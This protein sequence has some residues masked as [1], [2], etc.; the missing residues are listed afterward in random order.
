ML[1]GVYLRQQCRKRNTHEILDHEE[2]ISKKE[3]YVGI[4]IMNNANM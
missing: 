2:N 4:F 1:V 3:M